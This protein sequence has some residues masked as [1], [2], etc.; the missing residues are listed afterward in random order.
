MPA[1]RGSGS[2]TVSRREV[3]PRLLSSSLGMRSFP[4]VIRCSSL[5]MHT[6][7]SSRCG[8]PI[9]TDHHQHPSPGRF[10]G[11]SRTRPI[12]S[13]ALVEDTGGL[14]QV[15]HLGDAYLAGPEPR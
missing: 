12:G 10:I 11:F 5:S 8:H 3:S 9:L 2:G 7:P 14:E 1:R 13:G 15:E 6:W 4:I